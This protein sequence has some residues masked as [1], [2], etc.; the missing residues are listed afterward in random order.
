MNGFVGVFFNSDEHEMLNQISLGFLV[1]I[2]RNNSLCLIL[3][4]VKVIL[5]LKDPWRLKI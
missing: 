5:E 4:V 2:I 1:F 3:K